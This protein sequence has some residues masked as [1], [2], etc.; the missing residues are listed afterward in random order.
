MDA[1]REKVVRYRVLIR[2]EA[3]SDNPI[4]Y[5]KLSNSTFASSEVD[6]LLSETDSQNLLGKLFLT[7]HE[8]A[9]PV[10]LHT[11]LIS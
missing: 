6:L 2:L 10:A 8:Q 11:Q 4:Q 7:W 9:F 1:K 5:S 3:C